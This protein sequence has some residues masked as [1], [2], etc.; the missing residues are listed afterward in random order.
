[1]HK[2]SIYDGDDATILFTTTV[3]VVDTVPLDAPLT[4]GFNVTGFEEGLFDGVFVKAWDGTNDGFLVGL[5]E[6]D[7]DGVWLGFDDGL[8]EG[9]FEGDND[10]VWLGFDVGL[11]EKEGSTL[12]VIEG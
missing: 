9:L 12:G 5:F 2:L 3:A 8:L 1:M 10:G 6:G 7:N 11:N 4:V